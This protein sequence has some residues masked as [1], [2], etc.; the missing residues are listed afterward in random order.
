MTLG[1]RASRIRP[2][3]ANR[4]VSQIRILETRKTRTNHSVTKTPMVFL[5]YAMQTMARE[6]MRF[7]NYSPFLRRENHKKPHCFCVARYG[8]HMARYIAE[9]SINFLDIYNFQKAS[10]TRKNSRFSSQYFTPRLKKCPFM[11]VSPVF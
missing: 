10:R 8:F 11:Q 5:R 4:K 6:I 9:K 2:E 7:L 1:Y 3:E